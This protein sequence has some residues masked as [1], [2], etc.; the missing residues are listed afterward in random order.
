MKQKIAID[1]QRHLWLSQGHTEMKLAMYELNQYGIDILKHII[2]RS[3]FGGVEKKDIQT[4]LEYLLINK[5]FENEIIQ[6]AL[7][8]TA[9]QTKEEE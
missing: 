4:F 9:E 6:C 1:T 7:E 2:D 5:S 3:E 8:F